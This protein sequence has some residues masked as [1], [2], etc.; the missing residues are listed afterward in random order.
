MIVFR[1][2]IPL[3]SPSMPD[4]DEYI[5]EIKSLWEC[6]YLT[7]SGEKHNRL[8]KELAKYLGV[9]NIEL[10]T[11]GH[12]SLEVAM[13]AMGLDGEVITTP[14]TFVSTT[15]A[16]LRSGLKPVFCD[17][18]ADDFTI[19]VSEIERHITEKTVAIVA[20]HVYGNV[21]DVDAIQKIAEQYHLKV[22]YDAAHCFGVKYFGEGIGRFG[23]ASCF[24]FHATKVFNTVEGGAVC[25]NDEALAQRA[26][27]IK[28]FGICG[29][30]LIGEVGTNAKMNELA[31]AMGICNLRHIDDEILKRKRVFEF[32]KNAFQGVDG[33]RIPVLQEGV[34]GNYAYY[35]VI[36]DQKAFG[37]NRDNVFIKLAEHC[38]GSRRYFYPATNNI[39][40]FS[41]KFEHGNT[42]VSDYI[43]NN[44]LALPIYADLSLDDAEKI[45]NIV[46]SCRK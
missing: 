15:E 10:F 35:P 37:A 38:I 33:M 28:N 23:D 27:I 20:V 24:S 25:F 19:N 36:F 3:T 22:V 39:E 40:C 12:T 13:Q 8:Q 44:V 18:N 31:A 41:E 21:C 6:R 5:E 9:N 17:I 14:Y 11:N 1:E 32:Y 2:S 16:I 30:N 43:S 45:S 26:S 7:N 42:P 29:L 34:T 4:F 46:L